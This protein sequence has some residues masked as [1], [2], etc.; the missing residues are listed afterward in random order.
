MKRLRNMVKYFLLGIVPTLLFCGVVFGV[1]Q[2]IFKDLRFLYIFLGLA[3][4]AVAV[5]IGWGIIE[6]RKGNK[7]IK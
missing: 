1:Q 6:L 4:T 7:E 3:V 5:L 2:L